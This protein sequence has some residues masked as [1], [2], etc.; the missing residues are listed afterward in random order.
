MELSKKFHEALE[1]SMQ[2]HATQFRKDTS[3]PYGSHLLIVA[4]YVLDY[5]GTEQEAIAGLLHDA[6][7]DQGG[8]PVAQEIEKR[9]G[10]D[11][12]E[13]VEGCSDS[14]TT[15]KP[16]WRDRKEAYLRHLR[17]A[18]PSVRRVSAADKLH[19]ARAILRDLRVFKDKLWNRFNAEQDEILWYYR[20]LADTFKA[21]DAG[22]LPEELDRVVSHIEELAAELSDREAK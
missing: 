4:G 5:G 18:S 3:I 11:V 7:E 20:A 19:N 21:L 12:K 10:V 14:H 8:A 6:I 2:L 22:P 13:I 16:P 9:F 17:E 1:F 15:P